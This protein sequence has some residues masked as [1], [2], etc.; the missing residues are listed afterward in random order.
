MRESYLL[1]FLEHYEGDGTCYLQVIKLQ[2]PPPLGFLNILFWALCIPPFRHGHLWIEWMIQTLPLV[3]VIGQSSIAID[4]QGK[5]LLCQGS[6][7]PLLSPTRL[8]NYPFDN[9]S[10]IS[11][12]KCLQSQASWLIFLWKAHHL[13]VSLFGACI[14]VTT[15]YSAHPSFVGLPQRNSPEERSSKL[16][17]KPFL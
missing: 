1:F 17:E 5:F 14:W 12:F 16:E 11:F 2:R 6:C 4:I 15:W 8:P 9:S 3:Y 10:F 13:V 7:H